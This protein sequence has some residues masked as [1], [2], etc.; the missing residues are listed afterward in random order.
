MA[1]GQPA[2]VDEPLTLLRVPLF[3][4]LFLVVRGAPVLLVRVC[5]FARP[6]GRRRVT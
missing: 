5:I 1:W 6:G 4:A 3:L 2:L